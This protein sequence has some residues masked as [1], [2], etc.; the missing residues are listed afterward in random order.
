MVWSVARLEEVKEVVRSLRLCHE[1]WVA[2]S[3]EE[4][5]VMA[6]RVEAAVD[7]EAKRSSHNNNG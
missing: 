4:G 5:V 7:W 3:M 1:G 2:V 6:V